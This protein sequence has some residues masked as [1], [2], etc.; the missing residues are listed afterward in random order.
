MNPEKLRKYKEHGESLVLDGHREG[1]VILEL[2]EE[3]EHQQHEGN[4]FIERAAIAMFSQYQADG[5]QLEH[6]RGFRQIWKQAA[7]LWACRPMS[8]PDEEDG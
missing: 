8:K 6:S 1:Q 7:R 5:M 4:G 3:I 2:V